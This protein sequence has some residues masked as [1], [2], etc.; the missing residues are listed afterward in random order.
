MDKRSFLFLLAVTLLVAVPMFSLDWQRSSSPPADAPPVD[1]PGDTAPA[2]ATDDETAADNTGTP[3]LKR[4]SAATRPAEILPAIEDSDPLILEAVRTLL[5]KQTFDQWLFTDK[6]ARRLVITID[7][8]TSPSIP[9]R[10]T[11]LR[12]VAG[13]IPLVPVD[14][15]HWRLD[16]ANAARYSFFIQFCE[17]LDSDGLVALYSRFY[18]LLQQAYENLGYPSRSFHDRVIEVVDH[19]L[20]APPAPYA[21]LLVR[22]KVNYQFADPQLEQLSA[23]RKALIRIGSENAQR[24]SKVLANWKAALLAHPPAGE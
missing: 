3:P 2:V 24:L 18:P 13:Q 22:P 21:P 19:L 6:L 9:A 7:S 4:P 15:D 5:G 8:L 23:G 11:L 16:P 17:Q 12:P 10:Y 1:A 14:K 20:S